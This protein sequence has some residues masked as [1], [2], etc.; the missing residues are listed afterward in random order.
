[1]VQILPEVFRGT[2][3]TCYTSNNRK[4][5]DPQPGEKI[6]QEWQNEVM[7]PPG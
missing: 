1:M 4:F 6:S 2:E 5:G 3:W 7:Q